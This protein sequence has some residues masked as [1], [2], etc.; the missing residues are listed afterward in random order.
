M[1]EYTVQWNI[2][3]EAAGPIKAAMEALRTH[4]DPGSLATVFEVT[5]KKSGT[6][7]IVDLSENTCIVATIKSQKDNVYEKLTE[8]AG[9]D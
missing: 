2:D 4:R 8:K 3:L 7:F 5:N 6:M 9:S 1:T